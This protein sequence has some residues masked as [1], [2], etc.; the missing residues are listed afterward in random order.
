MQ[1]STERDVKTDRYLLAVRGQNHTS[2][3]RRNC[4]SSRSDRDFFMWAGRYCSSLSFRRNC[5]WLQR[6]SR[7]RR[8]L[9][10]QGRCRCQSRQRRSRSRR[11]RSRRRRSRRSWTRQRRRWSWRSYSSCKHLCSRQRRSWRLV[12]SWR[13]WRGR[14][15]QISHF[16]ARQHLGDL[17]RSFWRHVDILES[18]RLLKCKNQKY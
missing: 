13:S 3:S 7:R 8:R 1:N 9:R 10:R 2:W 15:I 14:G 11:I 18:R 6:R 16:L 5:K 12:G 4:D 17:F